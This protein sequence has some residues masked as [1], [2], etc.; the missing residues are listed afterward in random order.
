MKDEMI[1][2][3]NLYGLIATDKEIDEKLAEFYNLHINCGM[4]LTAI[5]DKNEFYLKHYADSIYYFEKYYRPQGTL[6]DIGAG[7]GFPGMVLAIFYKD[8]SVT[9]VESIG[10]KCKFL[11]DAVKTLELKNVEVINSRAENISGR[12]FDYIT[13]RGVS[14]VKEV[15]NYTFK[16]AKKNTKWI[17]YKGEKLDN[18]L[19]EAKNLMMKKELCFE[20][21]RIEKPFTRTY[22]IIS[23]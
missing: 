4:N 16:I 8:L 5:K 20:T 14:P 7:G 11:S 19:V 2:D 13:A 1:A 10:K 22:C 6:A 23:R 3:N 12:Q 18:E 17:L 9:L 21:I 15:L